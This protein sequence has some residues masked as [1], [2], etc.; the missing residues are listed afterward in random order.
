MRMNERNPKIRLWLNVAVLMLVVGVAAW[1]WHRGTPRTATPASTETATTNPTASTNTAAPKPVPSDGSRSRLQ[2]FTARL[3]AAPDAKAA[4]PQLAELRAALAAMSTNE[5]IAEIRRFLDSR[6]DASTRLGFKIAASG[7]LEEAPTLRTFL[8]DQMA[9]LDPAAAAEY[10]KVILASKD[11]P[12]EWAVALRN[13]ARGDTSVTGREMLEQKAGEM[14]QY[15]PWQQDPSVGFLEAFDVAVYL[16]G[17]NLIPTLSNLVRQQDNPA[18]AH[19]SFL[20][21]DRLTISDATA[22]LSAL[23]A[24]PETMEGREIT[25]ANYFARADVRDPAQRQVIEDYLLNP[26]LSA[27]ELEKFAGLYPNA[28]YMVS[29]NLLTPVV[30]PDHESLAA[31]DVEALRVVRQWIED[32]KF[33][34]VKPQLEAVQRRLEVFVQQANRGP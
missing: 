34:R 14:L 28:N 9:R 21:L 12:D 10:A 7:G 32:P 27:P 15:R 17:T 24:S 33:A 5:A 30:T 2:E 20:A 19:A 29:H 1:L 22:V 8:L 4:L 18:A 25:R 13:L 3:N 11:S 23:M 16:G 26:A 31:R 6:A